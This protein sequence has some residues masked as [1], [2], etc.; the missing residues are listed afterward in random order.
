MEEPQDALPV[1][2][3]Q[4]QPSDTFTFV[5]DPNTGSED[6][7]LELWNLGEH[8]EEVLGIVQRISE[9]NG[10]TFGPFPKRDGIALSM[11]SVLMFGLMR[12]WELPAACQ[13][14]AIGE[15][16][17]AALKVSYTNPFDTTPHEHPGIH[18]ALGELI[19]SNYIVLTH[20]TIPR[21]NKRDS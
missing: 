2:E 3:V 18:G 11:Q 5:R 19:G 9:L 20:K 10:G 17:A 21:P 16:A 14:L 7:I 15:R 8:D 1:A 13:Y 4:L 6:A 12:R